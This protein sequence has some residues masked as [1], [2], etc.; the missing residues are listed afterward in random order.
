[1]NDISTMLSCTV[2]G[3]AV[4]LPVSWPAKPLV[5][6]LREELGMTDT[7]IGCRNGDC[8]SC[9]VLIDGDSFKSCL[10]PV[11]RVHGRAVETLSG[12]VLNGVLHS[13][14]DSFW[15]QNGFQCGFCLAGHILCV[16]ELLR[17]SP[18]A[19]RGEIIDSLAGNICRCTGYQQIVKAAVSVSMG[20][21]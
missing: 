14:Q 20:R 18:A 12:I 9:T 17:Q 8:G 11:A 5:D 6:V 21:G 3:K 15:L 2:N 19:T 16:V 7:H 1:M 4:K 10:V 13:V